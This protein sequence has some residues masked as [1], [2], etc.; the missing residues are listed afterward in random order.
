[1]TRSGGSKGPKDI[2]AAVPGR[3][4]YVQCKLHGVMGPGEW[5]DFLVE[6]QKAGAVP[7]LAR[8]DAK[9]HIEYWVL[10][11]PKIPRKRNPPMEPFKP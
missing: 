11:G 7:L 4:L 1:M 3:L 2:I 6:C 9:H 5:N 10:L 8:N